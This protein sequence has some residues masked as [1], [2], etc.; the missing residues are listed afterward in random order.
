MA[1]LVSVRVARHVQVLCWRTCVFREVL[2]M[3]SVWPF[4][5]RHQQ[6]LQPD[7]LFHLP[8]AEAFKGAGVGGEGDAEAR[9]HAA[10]RCFRFVAA[11]EKRCPSP[12]A[13]RKVA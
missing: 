4:A 11:A 13:G 1:Y 10:E 12:L 3:Q 9:G 2:P 7:H 8:S 6:L 5:G